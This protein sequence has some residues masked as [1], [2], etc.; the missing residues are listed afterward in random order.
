[1]TKETHN[2]SLAQW[3][4]AHD[5]RDFFC[6]SSPV[7]TP[8]GAK[9]RVTF[10]DLFWPFSGPGNAKNGIFDPTL[11]LGS[12]IWHKNGLISRFFV[13]TLANKGR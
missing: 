9:N 10:F 11:P 4:K 3:F 6:L 5:F 1:L 13:S 12:F 7:Q 2:A 8:P